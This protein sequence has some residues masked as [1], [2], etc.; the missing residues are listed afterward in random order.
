MFDDLRS[1]PNNDGTS[2][3]GTSSALPN[4][5]KAVSC[6]P[7]L[8]APEFVMPLLSTG[9]VVSIFEGETTAFSGNEID[10]DAVPSKS[11]KSSR[12]ASPAPV[13]P[14]RCCG[15]SDTIVGETTASSKFP[16]PS[17][18]STSSTL[19]PSRIS[20]FGSCS[21]VCLGASSKAP[22]PPSSSAFSSCASV[23]LPKS[24]KSSTSEFCTLMVLMPPSPELGGIVTIVGPTGG[25][26]A[27]EKFPN[28]SLLSP[29]W[30][31]CTPSRS[32]NKFAAAFLSSRWPFPNT[33]CKGGGP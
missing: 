7:L 8:F 25:A 11:P 22:K 21:G 33:S 9:F 18:S 23:A 4:A 26:M 27:S 31:A 28:S 29:V 1:A 19:L 2:W 17:S 20:P 5:P 12:L 14:P 3:L 6:S 16:K 32:P 24:P 15:G 10:G 13:L 30:V